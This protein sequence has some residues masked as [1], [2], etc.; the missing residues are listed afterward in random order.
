MET[1]DWMVK[2]T[3]QSEWIERRGVLLWLAFFF[4][5]LGAGIFFMASFFD[6]IQAMLA[7]WLVCAILGGGFHFVFLGK[8]ARFWRIIVSSGWQTSWISR[9][10]IFVSLFLI[11]GLIHLVLTTWADSGVALL[12]V[13]D[14]F[15]FLTIIYGGFAMNYV[16]GIPLWNTALLP[17]LYIVSGLLGGAEIVLGITV[18]SGEISSGI[19]IEEW[20]RILMIGYIILIPIY[21]LSTRY[22]SVTGKASIRYMLLGRW[23]Q[24]FWGVVVL[25]G[26]IVPVAAIISS[27]AMGLETTP[28]AFLYTAIFSGLIGDLTIRYLIL[29]CGLY[30]PLIPISGTQSTPVRS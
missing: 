27:Y 28:V 10:L 13:I 11:L 26:I 30:A 25:V 7:G 2:Y 22:T 5:E 8:P 14:I 16:N 19:A 17:V 18:A 9:G 23:S 20:I 1:Y 29:R 21:L 12:V 3:P 24:V 4:I 6:N 15:A